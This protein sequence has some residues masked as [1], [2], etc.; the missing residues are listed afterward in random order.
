MM[1]FPRDDNLAKGTWAPVKEEMRKMWKAILRC[2]NCGFRASLRNTH[3]IA[4]D[5]TVTPSVVCPH[6]G[7]TF[8][9]MVKLEGYQP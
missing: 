3:S 4:S 6:E 2:P 5:G 7:C 1:I 8:H 9:E